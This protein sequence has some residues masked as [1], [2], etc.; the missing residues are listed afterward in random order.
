MSS[1]CVES[2]CREAEEATADWG[3]TAS[4][5]RAQKLLIKA[6]SG[7]E[8]AVEVATIRSLLTVEEL[9][10]FEAGRS[11]VAAFD[12]WRH[13]DL[14]PNRGPTQIKRKFAPTSSSNAALRSSRAA[15]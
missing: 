3:V 5:W 8:G 11:A 12:R 9:V 6:H 14:V 10:I 7:A 4:Q 15:P 2:H 1:P 13:S